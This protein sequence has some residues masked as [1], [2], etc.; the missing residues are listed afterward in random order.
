MGRY[1]TKI[2][3]ARSKYS[4][5]AKVLEYLTYLDE[6]KTRWVQAHTHRVFNGNVSAS[7]R[8][9]VMNR[10]LKAFNQTGGTLHAFLDQVCSVQ[11]HLVLKH[12]MREHRAKSTVA[13]AASSSK[14]VV[15]SEF[16][17]YIQEKVIISF[18]L[19]FS[20]GLLFVSI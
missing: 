10:L 16:T 13:T 1:S 18:V 11:H 15:L 7:T 17:P 6:N 12:E 9:E 2:T 8:N 5:N 4:D 3:A 19:P 14:L 20:Q